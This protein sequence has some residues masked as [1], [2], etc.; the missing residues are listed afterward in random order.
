MD[1][2]ELH[3]IKGA[4]NQW[5]PHFCEFCLQKLDKVL[6][7]NIGEKSPRASHQGRGKGTTLKYTTAFCPSQQGHPQEKLFNQNLTWGFISL[8]DLR[9]SASFLHRRRE[10]PNSKPL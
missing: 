9:A 5:S 1:K 6:T 4:N 7:V 2:S 10:I 8:I 3:I